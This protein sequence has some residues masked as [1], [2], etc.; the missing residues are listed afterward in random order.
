VAYAEVAYHNDDAIRE[1]WS[2]LHQGLAALLV[3]ALCA[4]ALAVS[5]WWLVLRPWNVLAKQLGRS[6]KVN[7]PAA[8]GPIHRV[9]GWINQRRSG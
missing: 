6:G 4:V 2:P 1:I 5:G 3:N 7:A 8:F 9:V